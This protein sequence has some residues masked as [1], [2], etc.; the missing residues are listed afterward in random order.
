MMNF[1]FSKGAGKMGKVG[2]K[3]KDLCDS[4]KG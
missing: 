2:K 4:D 3:C 1:Q